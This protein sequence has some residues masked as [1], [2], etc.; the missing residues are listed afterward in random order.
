VQKFI[1]DRGKL[2]SSWPVQ[3]SILIKNKVAYFSAGRASSQDLGVY[4]YAVEVDSGKIVWS[5]K[6]LRND[7]FCADMF[8]A[9]D[10]KLSCYDIGFDIA[11]GKMDKGFKLAAPYLKTTRYLSTVSLINYMDSIDPNQTDKRH[12]F[13]SDGSQLGELISSFPNVSVVAGRIAT[14]YAG[15]EK[16]HG[17]FFLKAKGEFNWEL[18]NLDIHIFGLV[19]TKDKIFV[20]GV[21]SKTEKAVLRVYALADGKQIQELPVEGQPIYDALSV[22]NGR[23][24]LATEEGSV[25]CFKND[26]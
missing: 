24:Y 5:N 1:G 15:W 9:D 11:T 21:N 3:S 17:Q 26:K 8:L 2:D 10:K 14:S 16:K 19:T 23:V 18:D 25:Y 4:L 6:Y 7:G 20:T 22:S 13:L 12:V